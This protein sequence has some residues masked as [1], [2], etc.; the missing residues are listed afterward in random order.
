MG[1]NLRRLIHTY[2]LLI[3]AMV[4]L[5]TATVSAADAPGGLLVF[6]GQK[7]SQ[8]SIWT[9]H[10]DGSG[11]AQLTKEQEDADPKWSPDGKQVAFTRFRNGM[12]AIWMMNADGSSPKEICDGLQ[13]S[14]TPDGQAILFCRYG[15]VMHRDLAS[16]KEKLISP[17]MWEQCSFA[18]MSP[19]Q[20]QV[21]CSSQHEGPIGL[22]LIDLA[23]GK[24][25]RLGTSK[26]A[27]TPSWSADGKTIVYQTSNHVCRIGVDGQNEED[28]T[29]G[30]GIQHQARFS[31]DGAWVAYTRSN[32]HEGPWT[33][34]LLRLADGV[35]MAVP[36]VGSVR[37]P[38]WKSE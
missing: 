3:G 10:P 6:S 24:T 17:E 14:W 23:T 2:M 16:G 34:Y 31:P 26:E 27:C 36:F 32:T 22:F 11:L 20:T 33:L 25:E 13:P 21:I 12:A 1:A 19:D 30:A 5:N 35:E 4:A 37:Y 18:V 29:F 8:W 38:D 28:L 15:Q 9:C 7:N